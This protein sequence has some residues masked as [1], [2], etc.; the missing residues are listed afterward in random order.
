MRNNVITFP[1]PDNDM[2]RIEALFGRIVKDFNLQEIRW[3]FTA[4][5]GYLAA[6]SHVEIGDG[7]GH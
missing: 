4:L 2:Q 5:T 7:E 3:L 1:K 6:R